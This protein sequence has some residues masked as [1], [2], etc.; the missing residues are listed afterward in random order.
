MYIQV[1][2]ALHVLRSVSWMILPDML[3]AELGF[4]RCWGMC[5]YWKTEDWGKF[6]MQMNQRDAWRCKDFPASRFL[7]NS[8]SVTIHTADT[9]GQDILHLR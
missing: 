7:V 5:Y 3:S 1:H 2:T 6:R 9:S 8:F 4:P